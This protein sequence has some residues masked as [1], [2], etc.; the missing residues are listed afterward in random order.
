MLIITQLL[1]YYELVNSH[2][3]RP[4]GEI[5]TYAIEEDRGLMII[6]EA[7]ARARQ[8]GIVS[9]FTSMTSPAT[10]VISPSE[11]VDYLFK[12]DKKLEKI[13]DKDSY[14]VCMQLEENMNHK[15]FIVLK[16]DECGKHISIYTVTPTRLS[17][18]PVTTILMEYDDGIGDELKSLYKICASEMSLLVDKP[19]SS[20]FGALL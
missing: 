3:E 17:P 15:G 9:M 13:Y 4:L 12:I 7:M 16:V 8:R 18:L 5:F 11:K 10:V 1:H 2:I 20:L 19:K 14:I 6:A